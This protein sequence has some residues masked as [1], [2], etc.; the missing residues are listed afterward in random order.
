MFLA[1]VA[2]E[3]ANLRTWVEGV[4][5]ATGVQT[6]SDQW[7]TTNYWVKRGQWKYALPGM[8][9]LVAGLGASTVDTAGVRLKLPAHGSTQSTKLFDLR[10]ATGDRDLSGIS[11]TT[12]YRT[13]QFKRSGGFFTF[14][15]PGIAPG[16][17][18]TSGARNMVVVD[19]DANQVVYVLH[20]NLGNWSPND[21]SIFRGRGP[22]QLTG[23][24]NYQEF[25]DYAVANG[26][27]D[28]ADP[29]M[30]FPA[31]MVMPDLL[32]PTVV[33]NPALGMNAAGFFWGQLDGHRLNDLVDAG[34]YASPDQVTTVVNGPGLNGLAARIS[35]YVRIRSLLLD[36][37]F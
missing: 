21:A 34:A 24:Y 17:I 25:A 19:P 26:L 6:H 13:V 16:D 23:R 8:T 22:F 3:T 33:G 30:T 27:I 20:N 9:K 28:P 37:N 4:N 35:S 12:L 5:P 31:Q 32:H 18:P 11:P 2:A 36:G 10:W 1:Q 29:F 7:F 14:K 15:L